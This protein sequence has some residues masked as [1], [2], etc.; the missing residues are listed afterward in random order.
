MNNLSNRFWSKVDIKDTNDCWE[1]KAAKFPSG[2]GAF[3]I[4]KK[5]CYAHRVSWNLSHDDIPSGLFVCHKCDNPCCVNPGHL[6]LGTAKDNSKDRDMK[7]RGRFILPRS[8]G[9]HNGRSKLTEEQVR[10]IR[11]DNDLNIVIAEKYNISNQQVSNI[12][13]GIN[14]KE[15]L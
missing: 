8:N 10:K 4:G 2:Y 1:W 13:L 14:W 5:Q 12:K 7:N 3:R 9:V 15:L 6:F 11:I